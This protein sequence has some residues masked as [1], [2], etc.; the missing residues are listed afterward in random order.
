MI[1]NSISQMQNYAKK[2]YSSKNKK[3]FERIEASQKHYNY[4]ESKKWKRLN[5]NCL[6]NLEQ[7][8]YF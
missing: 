6:I 7:T 3:S 2:K 5:G 4:I 8:I 1:L